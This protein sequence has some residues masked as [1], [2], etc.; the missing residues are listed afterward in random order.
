MSTKIGILLS[1]AGSTYEN[2]AVAIDNNEID[3]EIVQIISSRAG[4]YGLEIAQ[5]RGHNH[6]VLRDADAI[7][8]CMRDAGVQWILMCGFMRYYDPPADF[9]GKVLNI[10]P[11]LLPAFGGQGMYGARVHQAVLEK[12]CRYTGSTVHIVAGAYDS[13]AI[14]GQSVV[15][16]AEEDTLESLQ[17]RVQASERDLYPRVVADVLANGIHRNTHGGSW[18]NSTKR[19]DS[20]VSIRVE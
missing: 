9:A 13:G 7:S 14:V 20:E 15:A 16:V 12:G 6:C 4:V 3:A 10:H 19:N 11:S 5:Q 2:I 1:G 18:C 8:T 17:A